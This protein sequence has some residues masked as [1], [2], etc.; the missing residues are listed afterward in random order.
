LANRIGWLSQDL[1]L[2]L[3]AFI[4]VLLFLVKD[5]VVRNQVFVQTGRH[6]CCDAKTNQ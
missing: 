3:V 1:V 2:S 4:G 5:S 6:C